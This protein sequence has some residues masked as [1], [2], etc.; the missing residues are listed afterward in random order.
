MVKP[1]IAEGKGNMKKVAL[2]ALGGVA[3]FGLALALLPQ[4]MGASDMPW[5]AVTAVMNLIH[6]S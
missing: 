3:G 2:V 6:R 1:G 4:A 5:P